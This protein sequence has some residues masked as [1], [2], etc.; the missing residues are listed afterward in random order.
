MCT[1]TLLVPNCA[2]YD[3]SL[4]GALNPNASCTDACQDEVFG[5]KA[6]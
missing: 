5:M 2:H 1:A 6:Y 4:D 3:F